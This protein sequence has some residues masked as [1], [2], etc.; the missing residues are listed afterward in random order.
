LKNIRKEFV[1]Y[2]DD[3]YS[4]IGEY[5]SI[6]E[7]HSDVFDK[8][9]SICT[10]IE[11]ILEKIFSTSTLNQNTRTFIKELIAQEILQDPLNMSLFYGILPDNNIHD[12]TVQLI[13]LADVQ[14]FMNEFKTPEP[15]IVI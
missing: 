15:T 4:K 1:T 10:L 14:K 13:E 12:N 2:K 7:G 9:K 8:L 6:L 11:P 3:L 5:K